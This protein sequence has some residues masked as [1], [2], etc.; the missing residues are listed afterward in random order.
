MVIPDIIAKVHITDRV[1]LS[2]TLKAS[3]MQKG[4]MDQIDLQKYMLDGWS[5]KAIEVELDRRPREND[6]PEQIPLQSRYSKSLENSRCPNR[7]NIGAY[8]TP[9][10]CNKHLNFVSQR[11]ILTILKDWVWHTNDK[12]TR[13]TIR[14]PN[15]VANVF[16]NSLYHF[17]SE[18]LLYKFKEIPSA[19]MKHPNPSKTDPKE[20]ATSLTLTPNWR[21]RST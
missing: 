9:N 16:W 5:E 10:A 7:W 19:Y 6:Q 15:F 8:S 12:Q 13:Y 18:I 2:W 20:D 17:W 11:M 1:P 21:D 4:N 14:C 3:K